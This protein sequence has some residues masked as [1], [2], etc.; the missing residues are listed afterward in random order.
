MD[1]LHKH[2]RRLWVE[3]LRSGKYKQ[4]HGALLSI[5]GHCCLGV[6]CDVMGLTP[7]LKQSGAMSFGIEEECIVAPREAMS[8]V[9]LR[10]FIGC[11][12]SGS[13]SQSLSGLNDTGVS[14]DTIASIIEYEPEGLF[15][16]DNNEKE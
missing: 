16:D 1:T 3:A 12:S 8:A 7:T 14:F 6:L 11:F 5:G 2:N 13:D 15:V 9:G 10:S 4:G